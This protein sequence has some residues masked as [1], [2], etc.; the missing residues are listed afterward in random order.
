MQI[1]DTE[2]ALL[3]VLWR[4]ERATAPQVAHA[5]EDDKGWAYST[6]KTMLDRMTEKGFVKAR[7]V[8]T[9][10]EYTPAIDSTEARRSAWRRFIDAPFGGTLSAALEFIAREA[11]LTARQ[12]DELRKLL[13]ETE[14]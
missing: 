8:G 3:D 13:E 14:S 2:F 12:K 1:N 4:L 7:K 6:V 11:P 9:S 5:L 10:W